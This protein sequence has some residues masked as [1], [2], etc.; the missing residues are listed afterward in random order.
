MANREASGMLF[1]IRDNPF[2]CQGVKVDIP[3]AP[4]ITYVFCKRDFTYWA[5]RIN[6]RDAGGGA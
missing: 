4:N 2:T 1:G 6:D 5:G 3:P